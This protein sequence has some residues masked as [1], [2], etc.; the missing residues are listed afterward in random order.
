MDINSSF[1]STCRV[2]FGSE[3]GGL[4]EFASY[5]S[6]MVDAPL[7]AKSSA[8]GKM[9]YLS[10]PFYCRSARFLDVLELPLPS[11]AV[12]INDIK[13]V[14]SLLSAVSE[15]FAY[16][17]SKNLGRSLNIR[18]SDMCNDS[19]EVL[20]SQNVMSSKNV[21]YCNGIRQSECTFGCQLGGEVGFSIH[22]QVFFYSARCFDA[23]LAFHCTDIYCSFNCSNCTDAMF[24]FN[25]KSKRH[26]IGNAE[27]TREKYLAL[28]GKLLGEIAG[29]LKSKKSFPTVFELTDGGG[30]HG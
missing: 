22:S 18:Q 21:A 29:V 5:L 13:D 1:K 23:Y 8:S 28:K 25:Q 19:L 17:G 2:L 15:K 24:C 6:G 3:I 30:A 7:R 11:P 10:Q 12:S 20:S 16:C 4:E 14:D 26:A 27:L 9:V